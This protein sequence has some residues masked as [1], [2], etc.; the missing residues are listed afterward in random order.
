MFP[1][2]HQLGDPKQQLYAL[3]SGNIAPGLKGFGRS[4]NCLIREVFRG[5]VK[6]SYYLRS[7]GWIDTVERRPGLD[8]FAANDERIFATQLALNFVECSAHCLRILFFGEICKWFVTKFCCHSCSV[9]T[10]ASRVLT[11]INQVARRRGAY[12]R[13]PLAGLL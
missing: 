4:F 6:L 9:A 5:F 1:F 3:F 12:L 10:H 8:A 13:R 7:V 2:A 11:L